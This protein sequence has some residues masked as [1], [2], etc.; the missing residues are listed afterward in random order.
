M[1]INYHQILLNLLNLLTAFI[2]LQ[3]MVVQTPIYAHNTHN[4][5]IFSQNIFDKQN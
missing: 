5:D 4:F 3:R 2:L 1:K